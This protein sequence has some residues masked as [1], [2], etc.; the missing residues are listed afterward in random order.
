[1][2][3]RLF[4]P[5]S[6]LQKHRVIGRKVVHKSLDITDP[7]VLVQLLLGGGS[8]FLLKSYNTREH[9]VC[10]LAKL[11]WRASEDTKYMARKKG[12]DTIIWN[13]YCPRK[14]PT[15]PRR[16]VVKASSSIGRGCAQNYTSLMSFCNSRTGTLRGIGGVHIL[17]IINYRFLTT[18]TNLKALYTVSH[19]YVDNF[20]F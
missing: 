8:I 17:N 11:I 16:R 6:M 13:S 15:T 2:L 5:I 14:R 19:R 9:S 3:E 7:H 10:G 18:E 4:F 12:G 1:M 20:G